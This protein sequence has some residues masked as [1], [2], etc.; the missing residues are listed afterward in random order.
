MVQCPRIPPSLVFPRKWYPDVLPYNSLI[1]QDYLFPTF[2]KLNYQNFKLTL[3]PDVIL[4][5]L[6]KSSTDSW[7]AV[8]KSLPAS[9]LKSNT[10]CY[11]TL[12]DLPITKLSVLIAQVK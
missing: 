3:P 7:L 12:Q 1:R 8:S 10:K 6:G 9:I 4:F 5:S 2:F 11:F